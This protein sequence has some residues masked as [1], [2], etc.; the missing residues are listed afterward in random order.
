MKMCLS[1]QNLNKIQC[2]NFIWFSFVQTNS[3]NESKWLYNYY[4]YSFLYFGFVFFFP[5]NYFYSAFW[6]WTTMTFYFVHHFNVSRFI[7]T[8]PKIRT[9]L[10]NITDHWPLTTTRH[11]MIQQLSHRR[12]NAKNQRYL[13]INENNIYDPISHHE[14]CYQ[15]V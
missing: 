7:L 13:A 2:I 1:S 14:S 5:C 9:N 11:F 10:M 4:E 15:I 8:Q 12:K 6:S 3:K